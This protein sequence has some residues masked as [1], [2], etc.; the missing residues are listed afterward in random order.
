[1]SPE[2]QIIAIML[3]QFAMFVVPVTAAVSAMIYVS[4]RG[5]L[6]ILVLI[7]LY[8]FMTVKWG[9][10]LLPESWKYSIVSKV[11]MQPVTVYYAKFNTR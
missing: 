7:A 9:Q 6:L 4:D 1:M 8:S 10:T 11:E 3:F 5:R 2:N